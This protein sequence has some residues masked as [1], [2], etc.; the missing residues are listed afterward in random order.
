[1][2]GH[3]TSMLFLP[4]T[5]QAQVSNA[6]ANL[7]ANGSPYQINIGLFTTPQA[8]ST[9][10]PSTTFFSVQPPSDRPE[11]LQDS[12]LSKNQKQPD[13]TI[14]NKSPYYQSPSSPPPSPPSP[15]SPPLSPHSPPPTTLL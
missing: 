9:P 14:M 1:M 10:L 2:Q 11:K 6:H 3:P 7:P 15:S 4:Q 8:P 12:C 13:D 5:G